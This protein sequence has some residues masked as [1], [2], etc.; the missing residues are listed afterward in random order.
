MKV[1]YITAAIFLALVCLII[2]NFIYIN[3]IT[4]EMA[5]LTENIKS[6]DDPSTEISVLDE[7]WKSKRVTVGLSVSHLIVGKISDSIASMK[8]FAESGEKVFLDR[9]I[10]LFEEN[11]REL[12]RLEQFSFE[13]ILKKTPSE[14]P[15]EFLF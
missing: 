9:E 2:A 1:F 4:E 6:S 13:N 3:K 10:A 7:Y 5:A 12:R 15:R 14:N 8:T 11:V